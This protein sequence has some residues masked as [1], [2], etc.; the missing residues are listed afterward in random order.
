MLKR[1]SSLPV[2]VSDQD[3]ALQYYRDVLGF[4]VKSDAPYKEAPDGTPLRWLTVAIPDSE[5]ELIL[6]HPAMG[7]TPEEAQD[8]GQRV[9]TWTGVVLETDDIQADYQTLKDRGAQFN[10]EPT[11]QFWGGWDAQLADPDGNRFQM[12]Q[13]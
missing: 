8:L 11:Q 5:T 6:Y 7:E 13:P 3:R 12:I 4:E 10:S 1:V 2:F 9:G